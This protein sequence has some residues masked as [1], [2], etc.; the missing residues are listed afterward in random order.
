MKINVDDNQELASQFGIRGIPTVMVFKEG[1]VV[2]SM[3]GM[4]PR[5][6]LAKALDTAL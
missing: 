2:S 1:Q 4:K 3:V 6:E 5:D